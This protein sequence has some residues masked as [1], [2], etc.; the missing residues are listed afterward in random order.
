DAQA[1]A[2]AGKLRGRV[3]LVEDNPVNLM[4]AQRLVGL[5]GLHCETADNGEKALERMAQGNLDLVLM[6]CQM[7]VKDGYTASREWREHE[8]RNN[9]PRLPI[10]AM[11]ANAMAGDRQKCLDAG[12]DDYLSKPVDRRLLEATVA[13]W[14]T[15]RH[16]AAP[17]PAAP[18]PAAPAPAA[19]RPMAPAPAPT[20]PTAA[21]AAPAPPVRPT[22]P[23]AAPVRTEP[24]P[25]T[26]A[27][28][29]AAPVT[30]AP[31][32][33]QAPSAPANPPAPPPP[34]LAAEAVE[35]LRSVMGAEYLSLVRLFLE[36]APGHVR[37]LEAAAAAN[38]MS[39]MVAPAHTLKSASANLGAMALSAAAKRIELGARQG[40]LPRPAVA[41]AVL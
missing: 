6:D 41:V 32:A 22:A 35:E 18:A 40:V 24:L 36:D 27:P 16:A 19:P 14:L 29:P 23:A 4:V 10:I 31:A 8:V 15:Q 21:P 17:A 37:A 9:L 28:R 39:A 33:P 25:A 2:S 38:D 12:M 7:P 13:R 26:P 20:A 3:L 1:R 11:T 5:L 30:P 34:V